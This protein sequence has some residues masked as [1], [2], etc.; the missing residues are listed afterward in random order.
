MAL[1]TLISLDHFH[2]YNESDGAGD[3]EPYVLV[4]FFKIDGD[5]AVVNV[6]Q[7]NEL[8]ID[9][10]CTYVGTPGTH[11]NL[12]DTDVEEGDD[13]PVPAAVGECVFTLNPAPAAPGQPPEYTFDGAVGVVVVL[14]E[15]G[16]VLDSAAAAGHAAFDLEV[17]KAINEVIPTQRLGMED[18]DPAKI[19]ELGDRVLDK[20][21][22]AIIGPQGV[23]RN[24]LSYLHGDVKIGFD[25]FNVQVE[26]LRENGGVHPIAKRFQRFVTTSAGGPQTLAADYRLTAEILGADPS[27]HGYRQF[28][29]SGEYTTPP[30]AS[31]PTACVIPGLGVHNIAYRDGDGRLHEL[32][33]DTAGTTGTTNLTYVAGNPTPAIGTPF[34]YADTG[35]NQEV[36]VYLGEDLNVHAL[37]WSTGPVGHD[38]LTGS[39]GAPQA[40]S[41]PV[42]FYNPATTD[43]H[44]VYR[45]SGDHLGD[46]LEVLWW[47]GGGGVEH[48][49]ATELAHGRPAVGD[50]S[51]YLDT[52]RDQKVIVFRGNDGHVYDI[53]WAY[54]D[55]EQLD[56][57]GYAG[58]PPAVDDPFG[59]YAAAIDTHQVTY[60]ADGGHLYELYWVGEAPVAGWNLTAFGAPPAAGNPVAYY[61]AAS[62]TK[63]VVYRSQD[64]HLNELF[65]TPGAGAPAYVDL[66]VEGLARRAAPGRLA[67]FAID[68]PNTQHV[69]YRSTDREIREIR[70]T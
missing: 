17:E 51:A 2:C 64:G 10:T 8:F 34:A 7:D 22:D 12:G 20:V 18:V 24:I 36:L 42:G 4:A 38:N 53:W 19:A 62:N 61:L 57:S 45:K 67:A 29:R 63:H 6:N 50:P 69:A 23:V 35:A 49:D 27:P 32:W 41:N 58:T 9:G 5:T 66:T 25:V 15:E 16:L 46:H 28:R 55:L 56:L 14:L 60:R 48:A 26:T 39:V 30:A 47:A 68:G 59:Y 43:H 13:V 52:T 70:W 54:G 31:A 40:K 33:R 3:D 65:W 1:Q 11:G 37:Y 21:K 44:V